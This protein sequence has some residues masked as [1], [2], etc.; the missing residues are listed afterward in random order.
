MMET[1]REFKEKTQ[2]LYLKSDSDID[3]F[4]EKVKEIDKDFVKYYDAENLDEKKRIE[5]IIRLFEFPLT[6]IYE[7]YYVDRVY[8]DEYYRYYSKKHFRISRNTKRLIFVN[9]IHGKL[10]F[11]SDNLEKYNQIQDD[12]IGMVVLKPTKTIGRTLLKPSKLKIPRCYIRTTKFE[13]SIYG[14]IYSLVAFPFSGQ[15]SEVMTCAE[16]NIW[17]MMEY[18]GHRYKDYKTLLPSE[19]VDLVKDSSESRTLPSDGLTVEQE[20]FLFMKNGLSPLIYYKYMEYQE[21]NQYKFCEQYEEPS[22]YEI[23]HF[24]V[25]SGIPV[26]LNLREKNNPKGDN[27]SITCIGHE[28]LEISDLPSKMEKKELKIDQE[29]LDKEKRLKYTGI[30]ILKSW[31]GFKKYVMMEDHSSPYQVQELDNLVFEDFSSEQEEIFSWEVESFVVPLY[32][33]VFMSA[34]DVYE[35]TLKLIKE[36][37]EEICKTI[38]CNFEKTNPE[39]IIRLYLTTSKSYKDFRIREASCSTPEG[40]SEKLFYSQADYPKFLWICEYSTVEVYLNHEINGEIVFDAT[41]AKEYSVISIRHG[42]VITYRSPIDDRE[43][44]FVPTDLKLMK[45]FSMYESN[46]LKDSRYIY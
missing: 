12:L 16:V 43:W 17:Q 29:E 10:D 5:S 26:L 31:S 41:S 46:N 4:L 1:I 18:F 24:Y 38:N 44:A 27:H 15:D 35:I 20:S 25:E 22:F 40:L 33:H 45:T 2:L 34:E 3:E 14:R 37:F 36:N 7:P 9:G 28:H 32:K 30:N 42:E 21:S 11:I 19:L 8:R 6:V 13:L 23:L 39:I